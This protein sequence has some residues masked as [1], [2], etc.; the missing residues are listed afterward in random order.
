MYAGS[1]IRIGWAFQELFVGTGEP[2]TKPQ[3]LEPAG[4]CPHLERVARLPDD[5]QSQQGTADQRLEKVYARGKKEI[6]LAATRTKFKDDH[7]L[8][9][10]A[11]AQHR[12]AG[13]ADLDRFTVIE[14][15]SMETKQIA[16]LVQC[17]T[18]NCLARNDL[19]LNLDFCPSLDVVIVFY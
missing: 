3:C 13:P 6:V 14:K 16:L 15:K 11:L 10:G 2:E 5:L 8:T 9:Y 4:Y 19:R 7:N 17:Q 12:N 1:T 18:I